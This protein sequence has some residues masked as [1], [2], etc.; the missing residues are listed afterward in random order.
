MP[1]TLPATTNKTQ[2]FKK[3]KI[4]EKNAFVITAIGATKNNFNQLSNLELLKGVV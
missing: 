4:A 3:L 1:N 2:L